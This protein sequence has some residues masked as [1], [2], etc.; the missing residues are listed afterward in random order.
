MSGIDLYPIKKDVDLNKTGLVVVGN[1]CD[2]PEDR[3]VSDLMREDLEKNL[4]QTK[5]RENKN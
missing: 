4:N 2:V 5:F 1:K 3:V